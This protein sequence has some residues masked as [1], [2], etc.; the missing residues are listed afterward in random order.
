VTPPSRL[1]PAFRE[2]AAEL[3]EAFARWDREP[4]PWPEARFA[5]LALRSFELQWHTVAPYRA[6]CE[7]RGASPDTVA[8][9]P[10]I[11]PVPTAAFRHVDLAVAPR[12]GGDLRF[13][14]SG[15]TRGD[16][17]RGTH[18]V[19]DPELY[20]ASLEATF[21]RLVLGRPARECGPNGPLVLSLIPPFARGSDSSLAW[22]SDDVAAHLGRPGSRSVAPRGE[23]DAAEARSSILAC[24]EGRIPVCILGTTLAVDA[25]TRALEA[26]ADALELPPGSVLMDTGGAKGRPGLQREEVLARVSATLGLGAEAIVNEFG[27]TELLSQRY[28]RGSADAGASPPLV[29]PPWLRTRALDPV[30]LEPM[31]EGEAGILCH[32][33]LANAGSAVSVLTEDL[34]RVRDGVLEWIGRAPGAP[35]RGCSLATAELLRAGEG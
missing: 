25:W 8:D 22:M 32:T 11:P 15:T 4:R 20:R 2:L 9:W 3:R 35:P 1:P 6:Y 29:A 16:G 34:G 31:P 21:A 30:T 7:A 12:A 5:D 14:T 13:R 33:D 18:R 27:M 23:P 28:G 26:K 17:E 19:V 24:A 10:D